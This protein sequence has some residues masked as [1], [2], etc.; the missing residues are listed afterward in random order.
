MY[1]YSIAFVWDNR[2]EERGVC[3]TCDQLL[4]TTSE[5]GRYGRQLAD[6][7]AFFDKQDPVPPA[8]ARLQAR[9]DDIIAEQDERARM[10]RA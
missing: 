8:R 5:L 2:G 9:L 10:A 1:P 3:L 6:A 7:V 4:L